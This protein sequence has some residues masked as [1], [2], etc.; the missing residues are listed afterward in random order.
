MSY[1]AGTI[2][3]TRG[4]QSFFLVTDTPESRFYTVKLHRQAGDTALGSLLA[5]MKS[6]LGIDVDNLRLG[7]LAVWHEQGQHDNSDAFSLFTF[8]PVDISVLD[9]ERLRAV[10]LQFMNARQAHS[11]LENVDMS[12]VTS[13]D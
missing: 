4:D 13:L 6:E 10:G 11:L 2:I 8:E 12:G 9:F 5:G 1:V 7:E 3:F